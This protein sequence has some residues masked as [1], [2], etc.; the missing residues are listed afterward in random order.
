M[1]LFLASCTA[2][3]TSVILEEPTDQDV[4]SLDGVLTVS[5]PP[6]LWIHRHTQAIQATHPSGHYRFF[7]GHGK[8][9]TLMRL[10]GYAKDVLGKQ[11][12]RIANERHYSQATHLKFERGGVRGDPTEVRAVWHLKVAGR[13]LT[14]DGIADA[15]HAKQLQGR[16]KT[17]CSTSRLLKFVPPPPPAKK[18]GKLGK[19][20]K[21]QAK[22]ARKKGRMKKR[23]A[24]PGDAKP[25][26]PTP[27]GAKPAKP[28]TG[29][30]K[31]LKR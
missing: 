26:R 22:T 7:V 23:S 24:R 28:S 10:A 2:D 6:G 3:P 4:T 25:K 30:A 9:D 20:T 31:P 19:K 18:K 27:T 8:T 5:L 14:C 29:P 16:F 17:L 15:G 13:L 12:W 11:G 1:C 21:S